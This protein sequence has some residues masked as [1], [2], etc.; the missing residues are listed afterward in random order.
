[1]H[2]RFS[3]WV[4]LKD[5]RPFFKKSEHFHVPNE[6]HQA[7]HQSHHE[8]KFHGTDGPLQTVYSSEY[9]ASHQHWHATCNNL[10]IETNRSHM[11]GSNVGCWTSLTGVTPES[12]ERSYSA[13]AYYRPNSGRPNLVLLS[14]AT[15]QEVV[16]EKA[17]G[18][19]VAKGVRFVH[20]EKEH[21]VTTEGEIIICAGSVQSPQLLELSGIGN[22]DILKAA[23]IE[24]KVDNPNVGEN[25]QDHM[26]TY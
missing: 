1:M 23:G 11:S 8:L 7:K 17:E 20:G 15:V 9:G 19:W 21:V 26:S 13:T 22:P 5:I 24:S 25:L 16:L 14:E 12:R 3:F 18:E 2:E 10:G 4:L 6:D